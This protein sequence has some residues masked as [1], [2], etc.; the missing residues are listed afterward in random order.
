M[1][2]T[3]HQIREIAFQ[4]LF[5]LNANKQTNKENFFE[6]LTDGKYGDEYPKYLDELTTGVVDHKEELDNLIEKYLKSGWS[7]NRIAKTDLI[8][9]EI[10]LYEM[11]H[12][13]DL[14]AKVSINEAIELAKKYSDDRSRKFVN[15]ILSHALEELVK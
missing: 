4:T 9:L 2:L 11:L 1:E 3:R 13:D 14:P 12:V 7:I 5:A 15:G 6:V 10:A 8:I